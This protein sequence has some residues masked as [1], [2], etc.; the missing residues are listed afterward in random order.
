MRE[1]FLQEIYL[2]SFALVLNSFDFA[3]I[4]WYQHAYVERK[5]M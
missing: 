2:L 1:S 5:K 4:L 3:L